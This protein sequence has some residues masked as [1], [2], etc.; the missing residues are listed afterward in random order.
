MATTAESMYFIDGE[1]LV[2]RYQKMLADGHQPR[3]GVI[4]ERDTF[5]WIPQMLDQGVHNIV[6]VNYYT[7]T[8]GAPEKVKQLEEV[9]RSQAYEYTPDTSLAGKSRL[10]PHVFLRRPL[11]ATK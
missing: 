6:R 1:N 8:F 2:M 9:I 5:V 7:S 3:D 4:H 10:V 11:A